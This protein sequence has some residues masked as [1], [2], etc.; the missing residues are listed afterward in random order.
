MKPI[1]EAQ[2]NLKASEHRFRVFLVIVTL[3]VGA[4]I[5]VQVFRVSS[6]VQRQ[7]TFIINYLRCIGQTPTAERGPEAT[8]QCFERYAPAEDMK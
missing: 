3:V 1:E 5:S 4:F 7:S 6:Q 2:Q 8:N